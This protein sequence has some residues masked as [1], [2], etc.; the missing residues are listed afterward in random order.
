MEKAS[1][2]ILAGGKNSRI[3]RNK[4]FIRLPNG[5]TILQNSINIL[6]DIFPE[7]IIVANRKEAYREFE[8]P[9]VEDLIKECGPLGGVFTGLCHAASQRNFVTACD[10]P[11]I[12]PALIRLLL[13][14]GGTNDVV[15]PEVEGRVEPLFAVY[16]KSCIP[17][18]FEH[19]QRRDFKMR[20]ALAQLRVRRVGAAAVDLVDPQ[21][22]SFF[23]INAPEDLKTAENLAMRISE[24][25]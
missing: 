6:Q 25:E 20:E 24:A 9:V 22:L 4:A 13:A 18:I 12:S 7:I 2:L 19:L 5:Q 17:T 8:V 14:E 23:N 1:A 3:G 16:S 11:F 10:M 15:I 21:H